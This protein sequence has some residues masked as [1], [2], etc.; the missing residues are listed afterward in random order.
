[1][2]QKKLKSIEEEWQG[3]AKMVFGKSDVSTVQY[4]EMRKAFYAGAYVVVTALNRIGEPDVTEDEGVEYFENRD[5]ECQ[6]FY[7]DMIKEYSER[8]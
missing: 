6:Q 8:N 4:G 5:E 3:F 1:M 2:P 7:K